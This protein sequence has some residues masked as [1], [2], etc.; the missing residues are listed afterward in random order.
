MKKS[1]I[2][3]KNLFLMIKNQPFYTEGLY[4]SCTRCSVCCRF[5]SGFVFL[6]ENDVSRLAAECQM[7]YTEF[8]DIYCRWVPSL[9][10]NTERLSLIEKSDLDCIFWD[11]GCKVYNSRPL[12]C[13]AFPFWSSVLDFKD[14]WERAKISCPGMD[15]G[16]LHTHAEITEIL[17]IQ[18]EQKILTRKAQ[19]LRR[20]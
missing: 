17:N 7:A 13:K 16:K 19:I 4:F 15:Q 18:A 9:I 2:Y 12:Q 14:S 11:S 20:S 8:V 1:L 3:D 10:N 6:T 5:E